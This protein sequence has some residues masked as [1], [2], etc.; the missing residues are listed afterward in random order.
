MSQRQAAADR[1]EN[2]ELIQELQQYQSFVESIPA[3]LFREVQ[4]RYEMEQQE[5]G[6]HFSV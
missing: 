3:D 2:L 6:Q 4:E 5:Q 1:R